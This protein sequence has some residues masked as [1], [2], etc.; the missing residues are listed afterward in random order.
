MSHD[1]RFSDNPTKAEKLRRIRKAS[2]EIGFTFRTSNV[3]FN[4]I[5]LYEFVNKKSKIV[6]GSKWTINAAY[7]VLNDEGYWS[8]EH[9]NKFHNG[10]IY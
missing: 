5:A 7:D 4:N 6:F 8:L 1:Q 3:K 2:T 9:G 10:Q